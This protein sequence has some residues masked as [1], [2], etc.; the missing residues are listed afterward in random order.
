MIHL[1]EVVPFVA[2]L[3]VLF[4][5]TVQG[6][7]AGGDPLP[8]GAVARI[9]TPQLRHAGAVTSAAVSPDGKLIASSGQDRTVRVWDAASGRQSWIFQSRGPQPGPVVFSPDGRTLVGAVGPALQRW[10][11]G[12]GRPLPRLALHPSA[13]TSVFFSPSGKRIASTSRGFLRPV[14]VVVTEAATGQEL[15]RRLPDPKKFDGWP[16]A[17]FSADERLLLM[18][19]CDDSLEAWRMPARAPAWT[20]KGDGWIGRA[21]QLA[22]DGVSLLARTWGDSDEV[23]V[24]DVASG[25]ER[26]RLRAG[27]RRSLLLTPDGKRFLLTGDGKRT[28]EHDLAT[29]K[30]IRTFADPQQ[31]CLA[32]SADGKVLAFADDH[33]I[34]HRRPRRVTLRQFAAPEQKEEFDAPAFLRGRLYSRRIQY[35]PDGRALALVRDAE[36]TWGCGNNGD[37]VWYGS[38]STALVELRGVPGGKVLVR[39]EYPRGSHPH[40]T[41]MTVTFSPEGRRAISWGPWP[42]LRVWDTRTGA[43]VTGNAGNEGA[44]RWAR[45]TPD[46]RTVVTLD[47]TDSIRTWDAATGRVLRELP[48]TGLSITAAALSPNGR[49]LA[50]LE[51]L[52]G[53]IDVVSL[54]NVGTG[55]VVARAA[56][57]FRNGMQP[58]DYASLL[59]VGFT[60]TGSLLVAGITERN[61]VSVWTL[62]PGQ[63]EAWGAW[64]PA[65][66][67][68]WYDFKKLRV[69]EDLS[70]PRVIADLGGG[71]LVGLSF[72]DEGRH[73]LQVVDMGDRYVVRLHDLTGRRLFELPGAA[74]PS[75]VTAAAVSRK[76]DRLAFVGAEG[77]R[78]ALEV[79]DVAGGKRMHRLTG[80]KAPFD[81]LAFSPDGKRLAAGTPREVILD[82]E[83]PA[84]SLGTVTRSEVSV[85]D[86]STGARVVSRP[87]HAAAIRSLAFTADGRRLV[88]GGADTT[89]LI[90]DMA[91]M[92]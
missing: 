85:W 39:R 81:A 45:F 18:S 68:D 26:Y 91:S 64:K 1:R 7:A 5:H 87:A 75:G 42:A 29:G 92:R 69:L 43:E 21:W 80:W 4:G 73:L 83:Q 9:G 60:S 31:K 54:W 70:A 32:F 14:A 56:R 66:V 41:E 82:A 27:W 72:S 48:W 61:K 79:W 37:D 88:S 78:V 59:T 17:A 65:A 12:N 20:L 6:R 84:G 46:G 11:A 8:P 28:A 50:T 52:D 10:D 34:P 90:W 13:I 86:V 33:A 71:R 22:G 23:V 16:R 89:L 74:R 30:L 62:T 3:A 15:L 67:P 51:T 35:S 36:T 38:S 40:S 55:A 2:A 63:M 44:A 58:G 25:R 47:E 53:W 77:K 57:R 76:G 49:Y 19:F 24:W